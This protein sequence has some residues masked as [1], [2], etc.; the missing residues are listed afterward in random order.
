VARTNVWV[1]DLLQNLNLCVEPLAELL[2]EF[3][4]ANSLDRSDEPVHAIFGPEHLSERS[5]T[6]F[7]DQIVLSELQGASRKRHGG[8]AE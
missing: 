4:E 6:E 8:V 3:G 5:S 7:C 1:F 2:G